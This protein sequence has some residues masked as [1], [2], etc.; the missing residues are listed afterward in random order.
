MGYLALER[1]YRAGKIF[2]LIFPASKNVRDP[3]VNLKQKLRKYKFED[4]KNQAADKHDCKWDPI[5]MEAPE[6]KLGDAGEELVLVLVAD[7]ALVVFGVNFDQGT[8]LKN[9]PV[10]QSPDTHHTKQ[11]EHK[12]EDVPGHPVY[13]LTEVR[14]GLVFLQN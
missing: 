3:F 5:G 14:R 12:H 2:Y 8:F 4:Q 10:S 7:H 6:D 1:L 11:R 9:T 13:L